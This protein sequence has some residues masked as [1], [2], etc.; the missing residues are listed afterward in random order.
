LCG[1]SL[2]DA[3]SYGLASERCR[4]SNERDRVIK[5]IAAM[6]GRGGAWIAQRL[7]TSSEFWKAVEGGSL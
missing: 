5:Q 1:E 6:M 2:T 7:L 4:A 3:V